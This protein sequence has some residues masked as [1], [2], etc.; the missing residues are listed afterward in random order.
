MCYFLYIVYLTCVI[1]A[2][3]YS[4]DL[5]A[6]F[7]NKEGDPAASSRVSLPKWLK[8]KRGSPYE[9]FSQPGI[10]VIKSGITFTDFDKK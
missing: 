7:Q 6:N 3:A 10:T 2:T 4:R 1:H 9:Y 5:I 8:K